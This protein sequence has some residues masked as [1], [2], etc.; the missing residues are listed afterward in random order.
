M[1]RHNSVVHIDADQ[2]RG[3]A[4]AGV[5]RAGCG[6]QRGAEREQTIRIDAT[7][8]PAPIA[9]SAGPS[10]WQRYNSYSLL[11][12]APLDQSGIA[13]AYV[14]FDAPPTG[15]T[16]GTFHPGSEAIHG[17][18]VPEEGIHDLYVWLC[19]QAGNSGAA[20]AVALPAALWYDGTP[21]RTEVRLDGSLGQN[22]WYVGPI[23]FT[24][25]AVD[26][27][28]GL[29]SIRYQVDDSPWSTGDGFT[30]ADE[31]RHVVR[32]SSTDI[33]GNAEPPQVFNLSLDSRPPNVQLGSLPR[34][35]AKPSFEVSWQGY[36]PEPGSSLKAY[37]VEV[38]DGYADAWRTWLAY[39]TQTHALFSGERG[40]TYFFRVAASD[41][42][43]NRQS[44]TAGDTRAM[45]ETVLNGGFDTGN[46]TD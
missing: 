23:T 34:Y 22:G 32:I 18:A 6:G 8:P 11:W 12:T 43:G 1:A 13:G 41:L 10:G 33:A 3:Q 9:L 5:H 40:H 4:R 37:A 44:F 42:A 24:M 30:L 16:D 35:Q 19:D 31:G 45:V 25:S 27:T 36:D 20:S 38:R 39:T 2:H 17:L 29:E 28:A 14:K 21:P 46:F 7:P 26:A 15:P